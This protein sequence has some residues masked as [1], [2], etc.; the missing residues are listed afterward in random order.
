VKP[1]KDWCPVDELVHSAIGRLG[2]A[3]RGRRLE[4]ELPEQVLQVQVDP[5]LVEQAL[6]HLLENAIK[7][8]PETSPIEVRA[9]GGAGEA[10]IE[11]SDRG[12]GIPPGEEQ[13]IFDK[14]VR[15][16]D[17]ARTQGAG[18]G[19]T[20]CRAIV[21]A[22]EGR[23]TAENRLGGGATFRIVLPVG[24]VPPPPPDRRSFEE[25]MSSA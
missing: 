24:G 22:H 1:I 18:L 4:V 9:R 16:P 8:A 7:Y 3:L 25:A 5:V 17:G 19:L 13:R 2:D 15:L 11:V 10:T 12:P 21:R 23:I 6:V 20:V 14:F